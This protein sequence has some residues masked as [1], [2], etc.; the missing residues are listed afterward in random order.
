MRILLTAFLALATVIASS[1]TFTVD[2]TSEIKNG[3]QPVK[4][5][6][7][8]NTSGGTKDAKL[9]L[10]NTGSDGS[11]LLFFVDGVETPLDDSKVKRKENLLSVDLEEFEDGETHKI[12]IKSVSSNSVKLLAVITLNQGPSGSPVSKKPEE[13]PRADFWTRIKKK[14]SVDMKKHY[15]TGDECC[16]NCK[17]CEM[18]ALTAVDKIIYDA[19]TGVTYFTP[20]SDD[21][22]GK[23]RVC[24]KPTENAR[25]SNDKNKRSA[26]QCFRVTNTRAIKLRANDPYV[27]Q[28]KNV[29]PELYDVE[30]VDT[31][32]L[33]F[34]ESNPMLEK[35]LL[36][37]AE[38]LDLQARGTESEKDKSVNDE[39]LDVR[40]GLV[41]LNAEMAGLLEHLR[42]SSR[43]LNNC[44]IQ[45]KQEARGTIDGF[46]QTLGGGGYGNTSFWG[47][48][49]IFLDPG[50]ALDS[51]LNRQLKNNYRHFLTNKYEL[52]YRFGR[53]PENDQ[54]NFTLKILRKES[55]PYPSLLNP[56]LPTQVA[57]VRNFF[58]VDV[59]SGLYYS[60]FDNQQ[61]SVRRDSVQVSRAGGTFEDSV[62]H[63][64]V[65]ENT[66][67]GE[68]GFLS[69]LHFYYK[70]G[71]TVNIAGSMG[72]GISF[73]EKPQPRYFTGISV[74]IGRNNRIA[75]TGGLIWGNQQVLSDQYNRKPDGSYKW[76]PV[77]ETELKYNK[78]FTNKGFFSIS[79]NLPFLKRKPV[80][81]E[82]KNETNS[83]EK[84][85][86]ETKEDSEVKKESDSEK[87]NTKTKKEKS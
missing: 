25:A 85:E 6:F 53:A 35:F 29:N 70:F 51:A 79:Y 81:V 76:L 73:E 83:T 72:V 8:Y 67:K 32:F 9:V 16:D 66:G 49:D 17:S 69:Y 34:N 23:C 30:L 28:V 11:A 78:R 57:Y 33:M 12:E 86:T 18:D 31:S 39:Y 37:K 3:K 84:N 48:V 68:I 26:A 62:G 40:A 2:Y 24:D 4:K 38:G 1:Q 61:Y 46:I 55:S 5:T 52:A 22:G 87:T 74:L 19:L 41:L 82:T 10:T 58:K 60:K 14:L 44:L 65:R 20:A 63:Q 15:F 7:S 42:I 80:S 56:K 27:F 75:F 13:E 59:S 36:G 47:F 21:S 50:S 64:L 43:F 77:S 71:T 54:I 45:K